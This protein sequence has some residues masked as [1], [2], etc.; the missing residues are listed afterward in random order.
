VDDEEKTGIQASEMKYVPMDCQ[1]FARRAQLTADTQNNLHIFP[2]YET[3][4]IQ[5]RKRMMSLQERKRL[6][7]LTPYKYRDVYNDE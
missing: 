5:R 3:I 6:N 7:P 1:G 2:L 4:R